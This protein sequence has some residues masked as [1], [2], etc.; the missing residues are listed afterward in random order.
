MSAP[1]G[2]KDDGG[3]LRW[4]LLPFPALR[5]V[6]RVLTFGAKKYAP[7]NWGRVE[8]P[9]ERY[10]DAVLRHLDAW[11]SGEVTDPETGLPHLAH[12][13]CSLLFLLGFELGETERPPGLASEKYAREDG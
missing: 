8:N 9:R 12:A 2:R 6:V 1:D 4:A 5:E 3:K 7:W 13:V 11:L 10:F